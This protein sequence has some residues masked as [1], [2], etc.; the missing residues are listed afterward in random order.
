MLQDIGH[1]PI[2]GAGSPLHKCAT[3][4]FLYYPLLSVALTMDE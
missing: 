2:R 3:D 4:S 1:L